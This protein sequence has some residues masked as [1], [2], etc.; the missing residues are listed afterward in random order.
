M[1]KRLIL[2]GLV[3]ATIGAFAI[4][5]ARFW[6]RYS[7]RLPAVLGLP[8]AS[9]TAQTPDSRATITGAPRALKTC[10]P[11]PV[12]AR[13]LAAV[14]AYAGSHATKALV[15]FRGDC[16]LHEHYWSGDATTRRPGGPMAKAVMALVAGRMLAT[17]QLGGIDQPVATALPEWREDA[18]RAI[19]WRH[20]LAMHA[21]LAW[22]RQQPG[23]WSRFQRLLLSSDYAARAIALP[24]VGPPGKLYDYSA[25]VYD[26][27]G[28]A[29]ARAGNA[30]YET[31]ASQLLWRPLGLSDATLFVD[32]P[33]GTVHGNCCMDATA[34]DWGRVGAFLAGEMRSPRLVPAS[35]LAAMRTP[36]P[37]RP[38]YGLGV[39]LGSPYMRSRT[40]A[41][42]RNPYPTP[43][44]SRT[45][46][47][48]PYRADDVLIF[49]G[50]QDSKVWVIPS[51]GLS[52]VRLGGKAKAFD[53]AVIPN[54]LLDAR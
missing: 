40:P 42:A 51:A 48:V 28:I 54:L 45:F 2:A 30:P 21:G 3:A 29:L 32:R 6:W 1:K 33:G 10:V 52:I 18:R 49:E 37:D 23:P 15:V 12:E 38:D 7:M 11:T 22:Y 27:L 35:Y 20:M 4:D 41:S 24:A 47:S 5:D 39:W 53:D 46:Q 44:N 43:V 19:T 14:T 13:A 25:W 9:S 36:S 34:R 31:L 17:G 8:G 50:V 26:T 16:L